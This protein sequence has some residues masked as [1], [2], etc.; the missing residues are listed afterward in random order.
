MLG[1]EITNTLPRAAIEHARYGSILGRLAPSR[2]STL[3][4]ALGCCGRWT[5]VAQLTRYATPDMHATSMFM[6]TSSTRKFLGYRFL[7]S[8]TG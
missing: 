3:S 8:N 5:L 2:L 4:V 6:T 7:D 1:H